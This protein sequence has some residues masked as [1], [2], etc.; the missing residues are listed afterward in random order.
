L[1]VLLPVDP[2]DRI[3]VLGCGNEGKAHEAH[4]EQCG[5]RDA[6]KAHSLSFDYSC[7]AVLLYLLL[8]VITKAGRGKRRS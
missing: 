4:E 2:F 8:N 7:L 5:K 1:F 6:E 3:H